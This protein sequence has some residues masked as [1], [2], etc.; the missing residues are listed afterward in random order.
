DVVKARLEREVRSPQLEAV[1]LV[2]A[3]AIVEPQLPAW[4]EMTGQ[5]AER[6]LPS[7]AHRGS[8][9]EDEVECPGQGRIVEGIGAAVGADP[10]PQRGETQV[11][12]IAQAERGQEAGCPL[13]VARVMLQGDHGRPRPRGVAGKDHGRDPAAE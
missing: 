2:V 9:D 8:V 12:V 11:D 1:P 7:V 13:V 10:W 3:P 5:G 6:G 4:S